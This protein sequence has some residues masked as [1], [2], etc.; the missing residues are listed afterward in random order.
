MQMKVKDLIGR[1]ATC[2]HPLVSALKGSV[3]KVHM[4]ILP[5]GRVFAGTTATRSGAR[6]GRVNSLSSGKRCL[7]GVPFRVSEESPHLP[8]RINGVADRKM[9]FDDAA[10]AFASQSSLE[11][12]RSLAIFAACGVR[13]LVTNAGN[14]YKVSTQALGHTVPDSFIRASFFRHFCGGESESDVITFMKRLD[15][16]GIGAIL[17]YAAEADVASEPS[18]DHHE[19]VCDGNAE[20]VMSSINA[21]AAAAATSRSGREPFAACKF[22]G[23]GQP[24]LLERLSTILKGVNTSSALFDAYIDA[25]VMQ[26]LSKAEQDK[27]L[28]LT[29]RA[30]R[31]A[32]YA[33]DKGVKLLIDAEQ[34]YLQTAIDH[35][36][37]SLMLRYNKEQPVVFNTYQCYLKDAVARV[38][39]HMQ[40]ANQLA[41]VF[42]AKAVRGA[43]MVQERRLALERGYPNPIH[44]SKQSTHACYDTVVD[45]ILSSK[46]AAAADAR[47]RAAAV[48]IASHN[49]ESIIK[50]IRRMQELKLEAKQGVYFAQLQGMCDHV[51]FSLGQDGF[52]VY[53]YLPY[54]PVNEVMP[55]LLRRLEENS[56]VMGVVGKQRSMIWGELKRR[57]LSSLA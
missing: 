33:A 20:I 15:A 46:V 26:A 42:A 31:L 19:H 21:A 8:A 12:T 30:N 27:Y 11:L 47:A 18:G 3:L 1:T 28:R 49:E 56:D 37:L 40:S 4:G 25:K 52:A 14:I 39:G 5:E 29:A 6:N 53:K 48:M 38:Q 7:S 24:E 16:N 51:S 35:M 41:F 32:K 9:D 50:V 54:G 55:Y 2:S 43:Y 45:V 34:T 22:T 13:P 44:D 23:I 10:R 17:D 57:M 36:A